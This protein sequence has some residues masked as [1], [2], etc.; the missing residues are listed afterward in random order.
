[1]MR[2]FFLKR[3]L[4]LCCVYSRVFF[5]FVV[6]SKKFCCSKGKK[7]NFYFLNFDIEFFAK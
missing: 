5:I 1:M 7:F 4:K 3:Y 2:V 6:S